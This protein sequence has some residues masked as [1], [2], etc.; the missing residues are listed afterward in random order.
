MDLVGQSRGIAIRDEQAIAKPIGKSDQEGTGRGRSAGKSIKGKV[1]VQGADS[2]SLAE[3]LGNKEIFLR[4][5]SLGG[6][7]RIDNSSRW[8]VY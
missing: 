8:G 2:V 7:T 1:E 5:S 6:P 3:L 4:G